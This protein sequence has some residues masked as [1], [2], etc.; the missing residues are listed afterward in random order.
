MSPRIRSIDFLIGHIKSNFGDELDLVL[1]YVYNAVSS[2]Q[3]GASF[4][5]PGE[6]MKRIFNKGDIGMWSHVTLM[7]KF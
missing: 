2:F 5:L 7:V 4:F 1:S 3:F 6:R